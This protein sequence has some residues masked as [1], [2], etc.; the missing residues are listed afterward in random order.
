MFGNVPALLS[1]MNAVNQLHKLSANDAVAWT[2]SEVVL[3]ELFSVNMLW[4]AAS[5]SLQLAMHRLLG[6]LR[7]CSVLA[8]HVLA[9]CFDGNVCLLLD[10]QTVQETFYFT[11]VPY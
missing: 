5:L 2:L 7:F 6:V 8:S 10:A 1:H 4:F 3:T 9:T 11:I